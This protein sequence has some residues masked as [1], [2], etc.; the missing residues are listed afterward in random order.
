M[1]RYVDGDEVAFSHLYRRTKGKLYGH[2]AR[3]CRDHALAEDIVQSAYAKVHRARDSYLRGAPVVPWLLVIARRCLYDEIR[4][5][6]ARGEVLSASGVLPEPPAPDPIAGDEAR[7]LKRVLSELPGHY[8]E[9]I[10]LTKLHGLSGGEAAKLLATT[11]SA[12]K[13]RVHRGYQLL[14]RKLQEAEAA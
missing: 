14:R 5:A 2:I 11:E 1:A 7:H 8:L 12:V 3:Q 6:R 4:S 9:A 10:T 13:L